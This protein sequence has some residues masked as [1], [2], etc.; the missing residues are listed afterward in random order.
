M[1]NNRRADLEPV[2][3]RN[4]LEKFRD[5]YVKQ[6]LVTRTLSVIIFIFFFFT[7]KAIPIEYVGNNPILTVFKYRL[8]TILTSLIVSDGLL[9]WIFNVLLCALFLSRFERGIGSIQTLHLTIVLYA[10]G[11]IMYDATA[12]LVATYVFGNLSAAMSLNSLFV[13]FFFFIGEQCFA[14]MN[15][16]TPCCGAM[17]PNSVYPFLLLVIFDLILGGFVKIP[18]DLFMVPLFPPYHFPPL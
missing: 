15:G 9:S 11:A 10:I 1:N 18:V 17:I 6:P 7:I 12:L 13:L 16:V 4:V 8:W 2:D 3:N 5:W 14:N